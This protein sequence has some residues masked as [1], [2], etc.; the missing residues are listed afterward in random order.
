LNL[1]QVGYRDLNV[2]KQE[3]LELIGEVFVLTILGEG[4]NEHK[5][6]LDDVIKKFASD[7]NLLYLN[8]ILT[9]IR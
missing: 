6:S 2:A 5:I 1:R 8:L 4:G 7:Q 9:K 3:L